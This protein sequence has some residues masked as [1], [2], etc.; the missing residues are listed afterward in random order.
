MKK[1]LALFIALVV[2]LSAQAQLSTNVVLVGNTSNLVFQVPT[3][4]VKLILTGN[5]TSAAAVRLYDNNTNGG[6]AY[7]YT[8]AAYSSRGY[9][10]TNLV[11][12]YTNASG[13]LSTNTYP[14]VFTY[15]NTVASASNNLVVQWSGSV[16][17]NGVVTFFTDISLGK[18]L[19]LR[20]DTN[21]TVTVDYY[22]PF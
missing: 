20:T 12:T 8:N 10:T 22:Q 7:I 16:P 11:S 6:F 1:I 21:V 19:L 5:G 13:I 17:V 4:I 9:Y 2:G 3:H 15:T 14:G 18:G